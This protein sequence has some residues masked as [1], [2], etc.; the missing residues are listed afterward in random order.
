MNNIIKRK[1]NKSI[2][3]KKKYKKKNRNTKAK[4]KKK[5]ITNKNK[6]IRKSRST[7]SS[8]KIK[9]SK[10][11]RKSKKNRLENQRGGTTS[12]IKAEL[13]SLKDMKKVS[14]SQHT[15]N[16]PENI[17]NEIEVVSNSK[18]LG[19][20]R[21]LERAK[22]KEKDYKII[23]AADIRDDEKDVLKRK[24]LRIIGIDPKYRDDGDAYL[25]YTRDLPPDLPPDEYLNK[26]TTK[27]NELLK[28]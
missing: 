14:E 22:Q 4:N 12:E 16:L 18:K 27:I 1:K 28:E 6:Q 19:Y 25:K 7:K 24:L 5:N 8:R 11:K 23:D 15:G 9:K 26:I 10:N 3:K 20:S 2:L 17:E 13:D 21:I